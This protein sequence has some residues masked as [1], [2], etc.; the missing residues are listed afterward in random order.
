[1]TLAVAGPGV[2]LGRTHSREALLSVDRLE[3]DDDNDDDIPPQKQQLGLF[4]PEL[5]FCGECASSSC[6]SDDEE[7]KKENHPPVTANTMATSAKNVVFEEETALV[8]STLA[9]R[10]VCCASEVP[11]VQRALRPWRV[12]VSLATKHVTVFHKVSIDP[13][14][15]LCRKLAEE[16]FPAIIVHDGEKAEQ[17]QHDHQQHRSAYV[18]STVSVS[19]N[20]EDCKPTIINVKGVSK[21]VAETNFPAVRAIHSVEYNSSSQIILKVEHDPALISI[22]NVC[23]GLTR[24]GLLDVT[25]LVDGAV[26]QLYLPDSITNDTRGSAMQQQQQQEDKYWW[27]STSNKL[28]LHVIL[29]GIF[30]FISMAAT[31]AGPGS[32]WSCF[33]YAGLLSVASGLPPVA[34]KAFMTV[35]RCQGPDANCM[36]VTAALGALALGEWDEAASVSFLFAASDYLEARASHRAREALSALLQLRPDRA[37]LLAEETRQVTIVPA[38]CVPVHSL[39]SVRTGDKIAVDGVVVEGTSAIDQSSLTGESA[40]VHVTV[41]NTV[42]GGSINVGR[43]QLV[44]RTTAT[45]EDSAVSRLVRL[46]EDAQANRS[47]TEGAV[48]AFARSY[49]PAV[50]AMAAT[51]ATLPWLWGTE[52]GRQWTLNGLILIVVACPCAL[53]IS[54]PVTYAAGLAALAQHGVVCKGGASLEALGSVQTVVLDKTGTLTEGKFAVMAMEVIGESRTRSEMLALLALMEA[55][56]SHPM[57]SALVRAAQQE[58]ATIP[59]DAELREHSILAGEGVTA[60]LNGKQI[61]VGNR[62]LFERVGMYSGLPLTSK[63]HAESWGAK[64]GGTVGFIGVEQEGIV[65]SFCVTDVV[66]PEAKETIEALQLAGIRV[67]MLTGDGDAAAKSVARQ[68]GLLDNVIYS[69]LLPEEKLQFVTRL[70]SRLDP[71]NRYLGLFRLQPKVLFCGDGVNDALALASADIGVSMGEGA[72]LAMEISDV[73][74]M[75]SN[76]SKLLYVIHIGS[77]ILCTI[78]ENILLSLFCK[79]AVV[80]LTFRGHMT[81]LYAIASDVGVM[82]LVTLNGM[83]L[84]S[85]SGKAVSLLKDNKRYSRIHGRKIYNGVLAHAGPTSSTDV[86]EIGVELL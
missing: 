58:G 59:A 41:G 68:V 6:Y 20:S 82:L 27:M 17:S 61:Y 56:S 43:T 33:R 7:I 77:K 24:S 9:V 47:P 48:D 32:V 12:Q 84:L 18:E 67:L 78:R 64:H 55:S 26:E 65:G 45:V 36:M 25:V 53:T 42:S 73:T 23:T 69:Q 66:R 52:A 49:T 60:V 57:S 4:H 46:V 76:L 8:R 44:V 85:R 31:L 5:M 19:N 28:E 62:R 11:A 54:T 1:M 86:A 2:V 83:K 37:A 81:L 79:L 74:L 70:K 34:R 29:S 39:I 38:H 63:N 72:A 71:S 14:V 51:M 22:H 50:V 40:P 80:A 15:Q 16:G 30:W 3:D 13:A 35:T 10:G 21:S 75:D